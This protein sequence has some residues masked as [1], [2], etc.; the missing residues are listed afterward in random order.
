MPR[1]FQAPITGFKFTLIFAS[2]FAVIIMVN[3][4]LAYQAVRTFPGLEVAN[5][6]VASQTFDADRASQLALGWHIDAKVH[7]D[8]LQLSITDSAG[9]PVEV[10]ALTGT[11]GRATTVRDDEI[12]AFIFDGAIYRAAVV[13]APG[14]WNL[15]FEATARDGTIFRQ[16]VVVLVD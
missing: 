3:L 11:F 15:R 4:V 13:T 12:P 10:A 14:N 1:L 7:H 9:K 8:E 6:Y 16:R 5:S 2:F